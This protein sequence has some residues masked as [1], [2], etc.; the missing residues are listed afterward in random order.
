[1]ESL[2]IDSLTN[3]TLLS[4]QQGRCLWALEHLLSRASAVLSHDA[5]IE[6]AAEDYGQLADLRLSLLRTVA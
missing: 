2:C 5:S 3:S 4:E 6:K 1:M